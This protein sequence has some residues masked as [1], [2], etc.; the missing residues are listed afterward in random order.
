MKTNILYE[1]SR[2]LVKVYARFFLKLDIQWRE[3]LPEGPKLFIANHPS[4]TDPFLIHLLSNMSVL[5]TGN[6]FTFPILGMYLKQLGQISVVPGQGK[7]ALDRAVELLRQGH[8][9]GIFPEGRFSPPEGGMAPARSG[10]ARLA[11]ATGVPVIPVG[12]YLPRERC[13]QITTRIQGKQMV[14][15]WYLRGPYAMTVGT[16]M[17]FS[18][19]PENREHVTYVTETM[20]EWLATLAGESEERLR[21]PLVMRQQDALA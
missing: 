17:Q 6:A 7:E 2:L 12:I 1:T 19:D 15:Y 21:K 16:P 8:S 11:L 13:W 3:Q 9:V 5:I 18:G 20:M 10:A 4:A 14:G